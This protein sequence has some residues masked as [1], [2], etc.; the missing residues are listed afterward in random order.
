MPEQPSEEDV[1]TWHRRFAADANN[2]AWAPSEKPTPTS[3]ERSEMI[4][5]AYAAAHHWSKIG[6]ATQIAR[7]DLLLGRA[8]AVLG[9]G[10]LAM[11]YARAA[12]DSNC[13]RDSAPWELAFAHAVLANAAG[14]TGDRDLHAR[15]YAE[16]KALGE[17]LP[18]AEDRAIFAATFTLV[19]VPQFT[20]KPGGADS[21]A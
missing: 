16:A 7:A 13:S 2:R 12:F 4:Q 19:P 10:P 11:R 18:D 3:D 15:H 21:R 14:V 5:A 17:Q 6:S 9:N 20:G 1:K 8:H